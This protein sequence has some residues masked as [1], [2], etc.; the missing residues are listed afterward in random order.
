M[1]LG[2]LLPDTT[3]V[4]VAVIVVVTGMI[5]V[6][7]GWLESAAEELSSY[8]GLPAVVQGSVVVAVGSSF[9]ELASVVVTA[10]S[11]SFGMG[12][13]AVVGSAIFNVLLTSS[14]GWSRGIPHAGDSVTPIPQ[15]QVSPCGYSGS[16]APRWSSDHGVAT[17]GRPT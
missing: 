4:R 2:G 6:G 1:V 10:L 5:W 16:R 9:P 13:G 14:H 17:G 15:R 11:G 3:P 8:Y 7:S 12:V